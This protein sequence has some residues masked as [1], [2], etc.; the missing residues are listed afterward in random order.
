MKLMIGSAMLFVLAAGSAWAGAAEGKAI[1]DQK[2][3]MCHGADGKGN[4]GIAKSLKVEM[5]PL[6]GMAEAD[7]KEAVLKGKGKMKPIAGVTAK[8]ADDVAAFVHAMK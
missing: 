7:I 8:Q 4:P 3:K 5:K 2:C 6:A 1:Y